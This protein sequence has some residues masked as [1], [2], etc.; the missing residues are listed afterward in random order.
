MP[1]STAQYKRD[2]RARDK[3]PGGMFEKTYRTTTKGHEV[4]RIAL[5][6]YKPKQEK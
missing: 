3:L 6:K 1:K 5:E 4:L 2:Q